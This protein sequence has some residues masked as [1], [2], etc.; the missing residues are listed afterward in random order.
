MDAGKKR[1]RVVLNIEDKLKIC[2]YIKN[3]RS[4][5]SVAAEFNIGNSTV[6]DIVKNKAK[7]Q[8]FMREIEDGDCIKKGRWLERLTYMS[9]TGQFISAEMQR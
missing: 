7:L 6:Y 5:A 2:D 1:K 9:W 4:F 3:G 8:A